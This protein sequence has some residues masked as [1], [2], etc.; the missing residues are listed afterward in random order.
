MVELNTKRKT[1]LEKTGDNYMKTLSLNN[2]KTAKNEQNLEKNSKSPKFSMISEVQT[3]EKFEIKVINLKEED[4]K[5]KK[6]D[7]KEKISNNSEKEIN[8]T[9]LLD[10]INSSTKINKI[11]RKEYSKIKE[12]SKE[13]EVT[14][15]EMSSSK[16]ERSKKRKSKVSLNN[17]DN[18][19]GSQNSRHSL[20]DK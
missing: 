8:L 6:E 20:L 13:C 7:T 5:V 19:M 9:D 17:K 1:L 14:K 3:N 18:E 2:S 12:D 15:R 10:K 4:N 16:L 11:I